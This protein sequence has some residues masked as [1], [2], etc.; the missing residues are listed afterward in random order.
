MQNVKK[1]TMKQSQKN[2]QNV[3]QNNCREQEIDSK[4]S[5]MSH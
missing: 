2:H 3:I 5:F 1:K 4:I